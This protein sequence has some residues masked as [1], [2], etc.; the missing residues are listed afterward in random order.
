MLAQWRAAGRRQVDELDSKRALAA[1]GLPVPGRDPSR[2]SVVKFCSDAAMHKSE[3]GL[4]QLR[5]EPDDVAR[6]TR[7]VIGRAQAANLRDGQVL[8]EEMVTDALLEWFIGCRRDA[9]FGPVVVLGVGGL[10]AELFGD[11][12]IRL[13][14]L[15][16]ADALAAI[17]SHRAF[18]V[19][20][21]ARGKPKA[22]LRAFAALLSRVSTFFDAVHDLVAE[23]DLN[24]VLVRPASSAPGVVIADASLVLA[25]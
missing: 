24:P 13:A 2:L 4:V 3:Y 11:P 8:V 25:G 10:Y 18:P 15:D 23:V 22:D 21:G 16:E 20:D 7:D 6:A 9:T 1:A 12:V 14:P 17:R 19:I 5:I